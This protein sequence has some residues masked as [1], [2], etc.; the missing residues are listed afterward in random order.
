[1]PLVLV[2]PAHTLSSRRASRFLLLAQL[3]PLARAA[4]TVVLRRIL[5]FVG[6]NWG[7]LLVMSAL[8]K[9]WGEALS[10]SLSSLFCCPLAP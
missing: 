1:M 7:D 9:I 10:L 5:S 8:S 6:K 2:P 4:W 3:W